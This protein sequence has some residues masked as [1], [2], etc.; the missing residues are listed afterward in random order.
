M[1]VALH[2]RQ[3]TACRPGGSSASSVWYVTDAVA[4]SIPGS[5]AAQ[6]WH[7]ASDRLHGVSRLQGRLRVPTRHISRGDPQHRVCRDC[8][9]LASNGELGIDDLATYKAQ[10]IDAI[11]AAIRARAGSALRVVAV[12]E[13]DS[14]LVS[15]VVSPA[16]NQPCAFA[17]DRR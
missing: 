2:S 15:L 16:A 4:S 11:A 3:H 17:G 13:P 14:L 5:V 1:E 12:V 8:A 10:Y 9:A 6:G 7:H